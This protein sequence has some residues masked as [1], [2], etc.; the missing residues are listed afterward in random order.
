MSRA[1]LAAGIAV[2]VALTAAAAAPAHAD[3]ALAVLP[4]NVL[5]SFDT[6]SPGSIT[7]R[8]I[9]GLGANQTIRGIDVRPSN[10]VVVATAVTSGSAANSLMWTY[11]IDPD[12]GAATLVGATA[13]PL[14]GAGDWPTGWSVS[15]PT[16]IS[17]VER[18][19]Y[20]NTNDENARINPDNGALAGNDTDLTPAATTTAIASAHDRNPD[21]APATT[22]V[23][24]RNDSALA[25][26]GGVAG[27]PSPNGGVVSDVVSLGFVLSPAADGGLDMASDGTLYA[28]LTAAAD[29]QSR[30]YRVSTT[31]PA[32]PIGPIGS[33]GQEVRSLAI[34]PAPP[35][36]PA[37][38]PSPPPAASPDVT[39]PVLLV[40]LGQTSVRLS[41]L[42]RGFRYRFSCSE[43]CTARATLSVRG[44]AAAAATIATGTARLAAAG[45]GRLRVRATR[46]GHRLIRRLRHA[47]RRRTRA[48]LT[49]TATDAA[50]NRT[51]VRKRITLRR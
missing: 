43:A 39:R 46:S 35:Q 4:G 42:V 40:A 27:L 2:A 14:A 47:K 10:G 41:S 15:P 19:R 18:A 33:G 38:P 37:S 44:R 6:G 11:V 34:L 48:T 5:I 36:P 30:L 28:A 29:G 22:Y 8:P 49:T 9:V 7:A 25:M 51:T 16:A 1:R 12:T 31:G 23:I 3:R 45:K 21:G 24:D 17:P 13:G 32:T 20:V 50:N 26:L